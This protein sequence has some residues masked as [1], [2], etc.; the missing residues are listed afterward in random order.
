MDREKRME[1]GG[2]NWRRDGLSMGVLW[3]LCL[4]M[5]GWTWPASFWEWD[6]INFARAIE[7]FDLPA[8]RPHPPGFPVFVLLVRAVHTWC[9][10]ITKRCWSSISSS[11]ASSA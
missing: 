2:W 7:Q 5:R 8:H 3:A 4:G 11:G 10:A 1:E 9:A 6:E